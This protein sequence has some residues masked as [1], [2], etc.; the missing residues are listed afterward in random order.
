MGKKG[1]CPKVI[2]EIGQHESCSKVKKN[3]SRNSKSHAINFRG[4][5]E[6]V[7]GSP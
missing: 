2:D 4:S 7:Q 1:K 5:R 6:L 3:T